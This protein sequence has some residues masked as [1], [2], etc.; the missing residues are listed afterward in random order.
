MRTSRADSLAPARCLSAH[1]ICFGARK[2][3]RSS[4]SRNAIRALMHANQEAY[5]HGAS[6]PMGRLKFRLNCFLSCLPVSDSWV[7][8]VWGWCSGVCSFVLE[9]QQSSDSSDMVSRAVEFTT[10][11]FDKGKKP[12]SQSR[13]AF[14]SMSFALIAARTQAHRRHHHIPH[15]CRQDSEQTAPARALARTDDNIPRCRQGS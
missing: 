14:R 5:S 8:D 6:G 13:A 4:L 7:L 10:V 11:G 2:D 3:A 15:R 9:I 1:P 12:P